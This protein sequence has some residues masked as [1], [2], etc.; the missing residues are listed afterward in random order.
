MN[1]IF[2]KIFTHE[3]MPY[4]ELRHSNNEK[5]YKDHLH[6]TFSIGINIDGESI[7]TNRN[8]KY[9][10]KKGMLAVINPNEIHSC[11]PINKNPNQY[12]MLY[13]DKNWCF[14]I[15]KSIFKNIKEFIPYNK[16]LIEDNKTYE[17]FKTLC[18]NLF[19]NI[20]FEEKENELIC[21]FTTFF[22]D[23]FEDIKDEDDNKTIEKILEYFKTHYKENI[24]LTEVSKEFDLNL[25]Y[26][27]RLFKNQL[28]I[29]PHS[30]LVNLKI[31]QA[32]KL[33]QEGNSIVDVALE[34]GFSDQS[35]FHRNF[36][37]IVALTPNNY[38][39]NFVQD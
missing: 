4:L 22:E 18:E 33:L 3:N 9:D 34:C 5:R 2:T 36:T 14:E 26:I 8:N 27:I 10:F 23:G 17:E 15:Q 35:H 37:K 13:L 16:N 25:F 12:Y 1:K 38:R 7:Y 11:N 31:N 32:K 30:Y 28:K 6:E 19:S 20:P 24:S 39:L 29:T 21:F